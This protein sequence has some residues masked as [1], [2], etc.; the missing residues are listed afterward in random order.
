MAASGKKCYVDF[1]MVPS[2]EEDDENDDGAYG[3][4]N[5]GE[6]EPSRYDDERGPST[7]SESATNDG[8]GENQQFGQPAHSHPASSGNNDHRREGYGSS[9]DDEDDETSRYSGRHGGDSST[10]A[11]PPVAAST[12]AAKT[13]RQGPKSKQ[14][15]QAHYSYD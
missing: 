9:T 12:I 15:P 6:R 11:L 7:M 8:D 2:L 5:N 4:K 10:L 3:D 14:P 1:L 13:S